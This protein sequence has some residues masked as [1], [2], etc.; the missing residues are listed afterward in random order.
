MPTEPM[1]DGGPLVPDLVEEHDFMLVPEPVW[2][3]LHRNYGGGPILKRDV[4]CEGGGHLQVD[5][6]PWQLTVYP[7]DNG[8]HAV[9]QRREQI[10]LSRHLNVQDLMNDVVRTFADDSKAVDDLRVWYRPDTSL[11]Q[12]ACLD[13]VGWELLKD[14]D[15]TLEEARLVDGMALILEERDV[16][17][18]PGVDRWP[19][20]SRLR[21]EYKDTI[22]KDPHSLSGPP[23]AV[24]D[25][26]DAATEAP[27]SMGLLDW[28]PATVIEEDAE[29][30]LVQLHYRKPPPRKIPDILKSQSPRWYDIRTQ[31]PELTDETAGALRKVFNHYASLEAKNKE[32]PVIG[33]QKLASLISV[34]TNT[35]CQADDHRVFYALNH[36]DQDRDGYLT[37]DDFLTYWA[38]RAQNCRAGGTVLKSE[39]DL[40]Y[41]RVKIEFGSPTEEEALL[42]LNKAWLPRDSPLLAK[43]RTKVCNFSYMNAADR[44]FRDFRI[45]DKV[46]LRLASRREEWVSARILRV[47]W[48]DYQVLVESQVTS[49]PMLRYQGACA[50]RGTREWIPIESARLELPQTKSLRNEDL[51]PS[52]RAAMA[53]PKTGVCQVPGACGLN[54]LG[55]TCFMNATLQALSNTV[56]LREHYHGGAYESEI[57]DSP[58][59]MGG[60]LAKRFAELLN[61]MWSDSY[62]TCSPSHLKALIGERRPEFQG[63][64][65]HDAQEALT[66]FLDILHED[67]NRV[68]YPRPYVEDPST[69]TRTEEQVAE[70]SWAGYLKRN[71]SRIVDIFQFQIRSEVTFPDVGHRS[72]T[73]DPMMYLTLPVPKPAHTVK[74]TFMR[75]DYP[76]TAPKKSTFTISKQETFRDLENMLIIANELPV[77]DM[78]QGRIFVFYDGYDNKPQKFFNIDSRMCE[79]WSND[80]IWACEV[81]LDEQHLQEYEYF[82][83]H[84]RWQ[85]KS[86]YFPAY[87]DFHTPAFSRFAPAQILAYIPRKTTNSEIVEKADEIFRRIA[88]VEGDITYSLTRGASFHKD[89]GLEVDADEF[90]FEIA[91]NDQISL[92]FLFQ[93]AKD[94]PNVPEVQGLGLWNDAD[95]SP[96]VT[97]AMCLD[98]FEKEEELAE[99]DRAYC[100]KTKD[101]ERSL[102]KLDLWNTPDCLVIHL[103]RFG[104]ERLTGPPQKIDTFVDFPKVLDLEPWIRGPK[105][106]IGSKYQLYAVVNHSGSL[107]FGHY[108]AYAAVGSGT[109]RTW[110]HF[111]DSFASKIEEDAAISR[112][113]Y[114]LFYERIQTQPFTA[115]VPKPVAQEMVFNHYGSFDDNNKSSVVHMEMEEVN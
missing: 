17:L 36:Y 100:S 32:T 103:K 33:K 71:C 105:S 112:S 66:F 69:D 114:L 113:A 43:A 109:E 1:E 21:Q 88:S 97:L 64:L 38:E 15:Q 18:H 76:V 46:D 115:A 26:V 52:P 78:G 23:L 30:V 60:R 65:Q 13:S 59:S 83:L 82:A 80:D 72:L 39:L 51:D 48:D 93:D 91:S 22:F 90:P 27:T 101:F 98:A 73:F 56:H 61:V 94:Q 99:T 87:D 107:G 7:V 12:T 35:I 55:N 92:N 57:C 14:F 70:E 53:T 84:L 54:N 58:L 44:K 28:F 108:T 49:S 50:N 31:A 3:L 34:A 45:Y 20:Y 62:T 6:Y 102:K 16:P 110:F 77:Q 37:E 4:V 111:N 89:A 2:Q 11:D 95:R 96:Q 8:G 74:V 5:L 42:M 85:T 104:H 9:P 19:F 24:Y 41:K 86:T 68:P 29:R 79:V 75:A 47:D 25:Q 67:G 63:Y 81:L 40:L 10:A 106:E